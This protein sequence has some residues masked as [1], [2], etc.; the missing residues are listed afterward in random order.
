MPKLAR[1]ALLLVLVAP[2]CRPAAG[3]AVGAAAP[4][5]S[6]P[7]LDGQT[8]KLSDS[9]GKVVVLEWIN[10]GCPFSAR[11]AEEKIMME[12]AAR[13]PEAVWLAINSTA[14]KRADYREPAAHKKY[15]QRHGITYP[16]LYDTSGAVGHA[17]D[18]R[19]TPTMFVI[20]EQGKVIYEGAIDDDPGGG[21][22]KSQRTNYVDAALAA[23]AAG[24]APVPATT[25]PYGCSVKY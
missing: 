7:D 13:H 22:A 11:T 10:P 17:Y 15:N 5:F 1:L 23:H 12:T 18:A 6:L 2:A 25:K 14:K 8:H 19:S 4:D 9:R 21:K 16:V 24:T 20:D 3:L